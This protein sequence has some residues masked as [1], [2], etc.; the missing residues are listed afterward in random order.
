MR[1][2][3]DDTCCSNWDAMIEVEWCQGTLYGEADDFF[4]Y[5][6]KRVPYCEM[7][8][9]VGNGTVCDDVYNPINMSC[10]GEKS[11]PTLLQPLLE[12]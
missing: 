11:I 12:N 4:V 1:G 6:L 3:N 9:C 7:A 8:Y 5:K 10:S 2:T